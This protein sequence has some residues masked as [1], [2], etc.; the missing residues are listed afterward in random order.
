MQP[1]EVSE[2]YGGQVDGPER[3]GLGPAQH[4]VRFALV[5][6]AGWTVFVATMAA[7]VRLFGSGDDPPSWTEILAASAFN[8]VLLLAATLLGALVV[9]A[10]VGGRRTTADAHAAG[11]RRRERLEAWTIRGRPVVPTSVEG[12]VALV[13]SLVAIV[14]FVGGPA[15]LAAA[16]LFVLALRRG[17]RGL[18]LLL[19]LLVA[20]FLIAFVVVEVAIGHD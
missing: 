10:V 11:T 6:A 4:P 15:M 16:V 8:F 14:P 5:V 2:R 13:A 1:P 9:R 18:L 17:D 7:L 19:P 20:L 12:R 3:S